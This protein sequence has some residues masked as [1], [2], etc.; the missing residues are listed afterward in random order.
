MLS[1][2]VR[3]GFAFVWTLTLTTTW[4]KTACEPAASLPPEVMSKRY[5]A[6]GEIHGTRE[7]PAY[8]LKVACGLLRA[9]HEVVIAFEVPDD[10]QKWLDSD[11]TTQASVS[12]SP[13]WNARVAD[14]RS[15]EAMFRAIVRAKRWRS[16]G[17]RLHIA[18][19]DRWEEDRDGAM[20]RN[21]VAIAKQ[22]PAARIVILAGNSHTST[23]TTRYG[24]PTDVPAVSRLPRRERISI[25]LSWAEGYAWIL[26]AKSSDEKPRCGPWV[27]GGGDKVTPIERVNLEPLSDHEAWVALGT[28]TPSP[29]LFPAGEC[30]A[31]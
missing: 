5:I 24:S 23:A 10:E 14:G 22:R 3:M 13:H 25:L 18:G 8:A 27:I 17:Q 31:S 12:A 11:E 30:K 29:P 21:L 6:L 2:A 16:E 7:A 4:A 26:R 20:A 1:R 9:G 19:F 15:S 28:A